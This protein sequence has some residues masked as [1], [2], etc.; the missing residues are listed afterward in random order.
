MLK[1]KCLQRELVTVKAHEYKSLLDLAKLV[2]DMR[3]AQLESTRTGRFNALETFRK[4]TDEVDK[5]IESIFSD[6]NRPLL[7]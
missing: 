4:K 7:K 5:A 1:G 6:Q 3:H 2:S